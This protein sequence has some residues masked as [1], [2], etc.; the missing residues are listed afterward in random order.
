MSKKNDYSLSIGIMTYNGSKS[1]VTVINSLIL[2]I[3]KSNLEGKVEIVIVDNNST[4]D[5]FTLIQNI[6]YDFLAIYKN[7]ENIRYDRNVNAV[8]EKAKGDFVWLLSDNDFILEG[9]I[10]LVYDIIEKENNLGLIFVNFNNPILIELD[11]TTIFKSG[12]DFYKKCKFKNGLISS[13]VVNRL[14]W[15][16]IDM[17]RYYDSLW[18]QFGFS[19]EAVTIA[20]SCIVPEICIREVPDLPTHWGEH[21]SYI[22]TGLRLVQL[23][24]RMDELDY[25]DKD[26]RRLADYVI[27]G[28][29]PRGIIAAKAAGLKVDF[30][31]FILFIRSYSKYISFWV[32]DLPVILFPG[33]LIRLLYLKIYKKLKNKL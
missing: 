25:F 4:D 31:L 20:P 33:V 7:T 14:L 2:N 10:K 28:A 23:F 8:V 17:T 29:Y 19:I 16:Q 11:K 6:K 5:T 15:L 1:I 22:K 26:V 21:G 24:K 32:I 9:K 30:S 3:K 27:K 13:N 12:N 18:I